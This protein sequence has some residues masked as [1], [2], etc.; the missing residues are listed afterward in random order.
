MQYNGRGKR[1][2][3]RAGMAVNRVL[4][5][6]GMT[7]TLPIP[8]HIWFILTDNHVKTAIGLHFFIR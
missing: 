3:E 7:N 4:K 1:H 5:G 8:S 2:L 6:E